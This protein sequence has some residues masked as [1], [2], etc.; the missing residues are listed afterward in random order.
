[1]YDAH[2]RRPDLVGGAV[3]QVV[4]VCLNAGQVECLGQLHGGAGESAVTADLVQCVPVG[5]V[6]SPVAR[7]IQRLQLFTLCTR[8]S[9]ST[10]NLYWQQQDRGS[11]PG[12]VI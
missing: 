1:V 12:S 10:F 8:N 11:N 4:E 3:R 5:S 2:P 6:V 7:L 9:L